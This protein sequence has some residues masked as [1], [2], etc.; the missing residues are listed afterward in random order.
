M[1]FSIFSTECPVSSAKSSFAFFLRRMISFAV[2]AMS[3]AV[4]R[5]PWLGWWSMIRECGR[6]SRPPLSAPIM[7]MVAALAARPVHDRVDRCA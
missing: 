3:D 7:T 1:S 6:A 4:P 5:A 2:M